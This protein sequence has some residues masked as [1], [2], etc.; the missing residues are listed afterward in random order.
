MKAILG[1]APF[2]TALMVYLTAWLI[3]QPLTTG[4]EPHYFILASSIVTDRD[5]DLSN[6]YE[7]DI[8]RR[9]YFIPEI[10]PYVIDIRGDGTWMS[11]HYI[12]LSL[13]I[14]PIL[15]LGGA[16]QA[17]RLELILISAVLAHQTFRLLEDTRIAERA[18]IW[19]VWASVALCLPLLA[20]SNQVFPEI[21]AALLTVYGA[22]V[23]FAREPSIQSLW[24]A[25]GAA[26]PP[27]WR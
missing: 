7:D 18:L 1:L 16:V 24:L 27:E 3:M 14:S 26:A 21:T 17:V 10:V 6:N 12:G 8:I 4:D 20:Y 5:V 15:Y 19:P 2:L 23:V 25:A 11:I 22:R 13:L 9:Y